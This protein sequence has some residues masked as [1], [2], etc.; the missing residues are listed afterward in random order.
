MVHGAVASPA[1]LSGHG[2]LYFLPVG[3]QVI[4]AETLAEYYQQKFN[5][6]IEV[7]PAVEPNSAS[8]Y[9]N[10]KQY[11]AEDLIADMKLDHPEL[12]RDPNAVVIGLTDEDIFQRW[13]EGSNFT[14]SY[15]A[16]YRFGIVSTRRMDPGFWGDPPSDSVRLAST[17]QMLTK[18]VAYMYFHVP[19]SEDRTS[20]MRWPLTPDGG[21]DNL[22]ESDLHSEESANGLEGNGWPCISY[23]YSY[24][25]QQM[26]ALSPE[27][28]DCTLTKAPQSPDEEIFV[29]DLG[30]GRFMTHGMDMKLDST[31]AIDYRRAYLSDYAQQRSLGWGTDVS[32]NTGLTSDGASL[33][34][35][36]AIVREDG[37]RDR[38][39]R[40]SP[41]RGF[42]ANVAFEGENAFDGA[43]RARMT[44]D[45][46]HF[47]VQ[48]RDGSSATYL[49]CIDFR[50]FWTGSQ[51][52]AGNKLT[53]QRDPMLGLVQ[54][55]SQDRQGI[56]FQSD[57]QHHIAEASDTASNTVKYEYDA[58]G[59]LA[60]IDRPGGR[61]I[62]YEYDGR[63]HMTRVSVINA[64]GEEPQT[65]VTNEYDPA[66]H[67][68]KETLANGS[69]Y[70]IKYQ[71]FTARHASQLTVHEASGRLLHFV[72]TDEDYHE[73]AAPV[74][75][76]HVSRQ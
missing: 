58:D 19:L 57:D 35:Y 34:T 23:V 44:W 22:Y 48:Y 75:F 13:L 37:T 50:C 70:E 43:Y 55:L 39:E 69:Q 32:F 11:A 28:T 31:P 33:L 12:V 15:H 6:Q 64:P 72:L 5:I 49:S 76:P 74:R 41:G 68:V 20:V 38:L 67:I 1:E 53:V 8:Y 26:T 40:V 30:V 42:S 4:P 16:G 62:V 24:S 47:K 27:P 51:D 14:Y 21:S 2:R 9:P 71:A 54:V 52:A 29:V 56:S 10:R 65:L 36:I 59:C 63:H 61:V 18:Y 66:G 17:K 25:T 3:R 60:R 45:R 46:D 73:W 7:L